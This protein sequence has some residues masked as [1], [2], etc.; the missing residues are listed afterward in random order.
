M[1]RSRMGKLLREHRNARQSLGRRAESRRAKIARTD[2]T[3]CFWSKRL[4]DIRV[5]RAD[6]P[7][8]IAALCDP[9]ERVTAMAK[10]KS[11][12][13]RKVVEDKWASPRREA[14]RS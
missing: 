3:I 4:R 2:Y 14:A 5:R 6:L 7:H 11:I 8:T 13:Q 1:R 9:T 10:G 12:R